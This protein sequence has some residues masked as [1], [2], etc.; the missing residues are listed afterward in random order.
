MRTN[1]MFT[2]EDVPRERFSGRTSRF[3]E[4]SL[5]GGENGLSQPEGSPPS[6][7]AKYLEGL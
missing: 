2:R 5:H 6:Q 7:N 4:S 1:R 3:A